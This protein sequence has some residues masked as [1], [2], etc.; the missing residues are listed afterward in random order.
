MILVLDTNVLFAAVATRGRCSDLLEACLATHHVVV[1][2]PILNELQR[3]LIGKLK[4]SQSE[5]ADYI[6]LLSRHRI[7]QP[8]AVDPDACRD[9]N[10]LMILGTAVAAGA[11]MIVSGDQDLLV[12]QT[13][14]DIRILS[15]RDAY[16]AIQ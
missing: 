15:P 14:R 9:P 1:S 2:Q 13:F 8:V 12:L 10:D 11:D 4:L 16:E 6:E 3:H 7:V 5:V